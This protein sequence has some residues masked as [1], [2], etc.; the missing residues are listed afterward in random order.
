MADFVAIRPVHFFEISRTPDG[1]DDTRANDMEHCCAWECVAP[2]AGR[3]GLFDCPKV[4]H[5]TERLTDTATWDVGANRVGEP[6]VRNTASTS[7]ECVL[8]VEC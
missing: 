8:K 5:V 7:L 4:I 2:V 3:T 6:P 1:L